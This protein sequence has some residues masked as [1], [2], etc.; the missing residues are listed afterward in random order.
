MTST[1]KEGVSTHLWDFSN[2]SPKQEFQLEGSKNVYI[3]ITKGETLDTQFNAFCL[4]TGCHALINIHSICKL[5]DLDITV[6]QR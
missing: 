2:M 5:V 1:F 3:K 4:N 6:N